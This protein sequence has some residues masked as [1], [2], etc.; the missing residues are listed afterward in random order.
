M[1]ITI[2]ASV[3]RLDETLKEWGIKDYTT[4]PF[5][6]AQWNTDPEWANTQV[7]VTFANGRVLAERER[8]LT[9]DSD[10]FVTYMDDYGIIREKE[11]ATT[12]AWSY[13]NRASFDAPEAL[14]IEYQERLI[15]AQR[16]HRANTLIKERKERQQ[17]LSA[18]NMSFKD[19]LKLKRSIGVK[20]TNSIIDM[21]SKKIRSPFKKSIINQV[22]EWLANPEPK[23]KTPLSERQLIAVGNITNG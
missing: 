7:L 21:M 13:P 9:Q 11:Y 12:R 3:D 6:A 15:K 20:T 18:A 16:Y 10:F 1:P 19:Y 8:N 17:R 2:Q 14:F 23:Y 5:P 22:R 4:V